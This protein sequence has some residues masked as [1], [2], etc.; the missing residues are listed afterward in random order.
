VY[1]G[2][3]RAVATASAGLLGLGVSWVASKSGDKLE[4][5]I[6]TGSLFLLGMHP[7][8]NLSIVV[9]DRRL[10]TP[11]ATSANM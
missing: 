3:N 1:K 2:F 10:V 9:T 4:P 5:I 11:C 8:L 6:T 7:L